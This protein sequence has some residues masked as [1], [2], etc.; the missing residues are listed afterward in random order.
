LYKVEVSS[1]G[2]VQFH[3]VD[4]GNRSET[5]VNPNVISILKDRRGTLW[6]G[7]DGGFLY[8]LLP[9]GRADHYAHHESPWAQIS[10]LLEDREGNIW[11]GTRIGVRGELLRVGVDPEQSHSIV[12]Q[13]YGTKE[14]LAAGWINSL[15]QTRDGKLWAATTTGL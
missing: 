6:C 5:V 14:E 10:A 1:D 3:F 15:F 13:T 12:V 4:L 9:D 2:K 11:V 7:T 8:R